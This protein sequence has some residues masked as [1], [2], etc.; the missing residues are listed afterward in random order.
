MPNILGR[1]LPNLLSKL[2]NFNL[3]GDAKITRNS[4]EVIAITDTQLGSIQSNILMNHLNDEF[5]TTY[6]GTYQLKIS[7]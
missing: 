3:R 2:G 6:K 1:S 5:E 4:L 7:I